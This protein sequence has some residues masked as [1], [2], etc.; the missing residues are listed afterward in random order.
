MVAVNVMKYHKTGNT[1]ATNMK[2]KIQIKFLQ[3][4]HVV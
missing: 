4:R 3:V 1:L 2:M